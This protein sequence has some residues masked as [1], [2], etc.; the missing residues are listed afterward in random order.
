MA[1]RVKRVQE[2]ASTEDGLRVFVERYWP[3]DVAAEQA[4]LHTWLRDVAPSPVAIAGWAHKPERWEDF[5]RR[6]RAELMRPDLDVAISDLRGQAVAG[7]LTLVHGSRRYS[8]STALVL[9]DFLGVPLEP[10]LEVPSDAQTARMRRLNRPPRDTSWS[11]WIASIVALMSPLLSFLLI[12]L[13]L[14]F[15]LT[16]LIALAVAIGLAALATGV[17]NRDRERPLWNFGRG[18]SAP[19]DTE[20]VWRS[21]GQFLLPVGATVLVVLGFLALVEVLNFVAR[22]FFASG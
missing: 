21:L 14:V 7:T 13:V 2:P 8:R 6:Y 12:E 15:H 22:H 20:P 18:R 3:R 17:R 9:A 1:I 16:A 4:Q 10:S 11:F 19:R 5:K